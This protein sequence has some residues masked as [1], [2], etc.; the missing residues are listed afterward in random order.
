M[1]TPWCYNIELFKQKKAIKKR[2]ISNKMFK[3]IIIA[4]ETIDATPP[5]STMIKWTKLSH[6]RPWT[7]RATGLLKLHVSN[8]KQ[9]NM[10]SINPKRISVERDERTNE[11]TVKTKKRMCCWPHFY[12]QAV[13]VFVYKVNFKIWWGIILIS[14]HVF[15]LLSYMHFSGMVPI[16]IVLCSYSDETPRNLKNLCIIGMELIMKTFW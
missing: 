5:P 6:L 4:R 3:S 15:W 7:I 14:I 8:D 2:S 13:P 10:S 11:N 12:E 16:V 9:F 1:F